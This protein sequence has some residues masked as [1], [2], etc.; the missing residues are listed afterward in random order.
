[1]SL[2]GDTK[3]KAC[4]ITLLVT[5]YPKV[6]CLFILGKAQ[7][8]TILDAKSSREYSHCKI[9]PATGSYR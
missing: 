1:M 4:M 8:R 2:N 9:S 5:P 6:G 7:M 3:A